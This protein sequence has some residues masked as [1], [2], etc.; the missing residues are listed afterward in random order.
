M[1]NLPPLELLG[2]PAAQIAA[3][4][5][6]VPIADIDEDPDQPRVE[7]EDEPLKELAATIAERGVR[8]PVSVRPHP[9]DPGRWVLN[10]GARRLRASKLIG[11][12]EIPAFVDKAADSYDQVIE[13]EQR[14]GLKPL[15]LALFVKRELGKGVSQAEIARRLGKSQT[16]ITFVRAMIDPPAWLL[17]VYRSGKC[18]NAAQLYELRRLHETKPECVEK[19]LESLDR[20]GRVHIDRMR[21]DDGL[22]KAGAIDG[23]ISNPDDQ[24]DANA[25]GRLDSQARADRPQPGFKGS[26]ILTAKYKGSEVQVEFGRLPAK[27]ATVYV[28]SP[29]IVGRAVAEIKALTELKLARSTA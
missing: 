17:D 28:T 3:R 26:M 19:Q 23:R 22:S 4:P 25:P 24:S 6:M 27:P 12:S 7:F 8:S 13:N 5:L 14:E 2:L 18:R 11:L 16:Y 10:Y 1:L 29:A 9:H 15:E 20:I 21:K